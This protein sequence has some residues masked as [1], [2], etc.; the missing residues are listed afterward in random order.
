C[1][2]IFISDVDISVSPPRQQQRRIISKPQNHGDG[3]K[4]PQVLL[5]A[6]AAWGK[7]NVG[8]FLDLTRDSEDGFE[9]GSSSSSESES[10]VSETDP[11]CEL[12]FGSKSDGDFLRAS[13]SSTTPASEMEAIYVASSGSEDEEKKERGGTGEG[14]GGGGGG[15]GGG[16]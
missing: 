10:E 3:Q 16:G 1:F 8:D 12:I 6:E 2:S 5:K 4:T 9:E 14:R 11:E 13:P 7:G 15:G